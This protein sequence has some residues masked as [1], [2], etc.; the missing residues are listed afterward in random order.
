MAACGL[1]LVTALSLL[2]AAASLVAEHGLW[3]V[4]SVVAMH[5]GLVALLQVGSSWTRD[6]PVFLALAGGF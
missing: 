2:I 1:S 4:G 6:Q 3:S 5:T